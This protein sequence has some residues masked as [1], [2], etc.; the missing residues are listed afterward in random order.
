MTDNVKG[1]GWRISVEHVPATA[2]RPRRLCMLPCLYD[3][4]FLEKIYSNLQGISTKR[5]R[6]KTPP[7]NLMCKVSTEFIRKKIEKSILSRNEP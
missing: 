3:C 2:Q 4:P 7:L 6:K 5:K 1:R